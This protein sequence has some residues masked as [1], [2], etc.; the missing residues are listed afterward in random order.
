LRSFASPHDAPATFESRLF[1]FVL[2]SMLLHALALLVFGTSSGGRGAQH[3]AEPWGG[4]DVTLRRL[5]P[6]SGSGIRLA[7]G[8]ETN[9][10]GAAILRRPGRAPA[11]PAAQEIA[12]TTAPPAAEALPAEPTTPSA[13]PA[14]PAPLPSATAPAQESAAPTPT[15]PFEAL[16]PL[17]RSAPEVV[18]RPFAPAIP[19]PASKAEPA[20]APAVERTPAPAIERTPAPAIERTPAPAV[21]RT[22]APAVE[23]TP[24]PAVERTPAREVPTPPSPQPV[25]RAPPK[26]ET[27]PAVVAPPREAPVLPT[28]QPVEPAAPRKVDREV[29]PAVEP[30]SERP[31]SPPLPPVERITAP[32]IE[33]QI[34]PPSEAPAPRRAPVET[35]APSERMAPPTE[36]APPAVAPGKAPTPPVRT[37]APSEPGPRLRFGAPDPG[38][39]IF[40][41]RGDPAPAADPGG[42]PRLD[43]EATRQRA[44][45]IV[46]EGSAYRGFVPAI[47]PPPV[48]RKSK[49]AEA[50]D[51]AQ[52]PDC[53]DAYAAMGLLAVPALV[54]SAVGNGGCRW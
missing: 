51:K 17:N 47:P 41:P 24:A 29:A 27:E 4:L 16:P 20:S 52:K 37:E 42:A 12:P 25:E 38:D 49:L 8:D 10:S 1:R 50:I 32:K 35:D 36:R 15:S 45:E 22:P 19:A 2:I 3:G 5:S 46:S 31:A 48:E 13:A 21:E 23:R 33:P 26:V 11:A 7:P 34:A 14:E 6:E 39:E 30:P 54:V 9:T 28:S 43:L 18:D 53:R 44:R 40:K